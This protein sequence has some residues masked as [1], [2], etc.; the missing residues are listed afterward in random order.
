MPRSSFLFERWKRPAFFGP[1]LAI[2]TAPTDQGYIKKGD[3]NYF[4]KATHDSWHQLVSY[5]LT[6]NYLQLRGGLVRVMD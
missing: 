4:R 5:F 6:W 3:S 1:Q 2:E